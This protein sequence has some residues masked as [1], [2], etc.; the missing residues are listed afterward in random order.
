MVVSNR[1]HPPPENTVPAKRL[2]AVLTP[3][4]AA[5]ADVSVEFKMRHQEVLEASKGR[6]LLKAVSLAQIKDRPALASVVSMMQTIRQ[7]LPNHALPPRFSIFL[8][9][10]KHHVKATTLLYQQHT[11]NCTDTRKSHF[12]LF[13]DLIGNHWQVGTK[14]PRRSII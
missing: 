3:S 13:T 8:Q 9:N 2:Q 10:Y 12:F 14:S 7:M 6:E 11:N 4:G 5:S 1:S